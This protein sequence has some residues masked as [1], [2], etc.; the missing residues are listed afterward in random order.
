MRSATNYERHH[1]RFSCTW[2]MSWI[3]PL[4]YQFYRGLFQKSY[5]AS[6]RSFTSK[7]HS[8][9]SMHI[10][11]E[12][13]HTKCGPLYGYVSRWP[14]VNQRPPVHHQGWMICDQETIFCWVPVKQT[15]EPM[16]GFFLNPEPEV[17]NKIKGLSCHSNNFC[18]LCN[19]FQCQSM[20]G[21]LLSSTFPPPKA[22]HFWRFSSLIKPSVQS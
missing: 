6:V 15:L 19:P 4:D 7:V 10:T 8:P 12:T 1:T 20:D 9:Q 16:P 17:I 21:M 18:L 2:R 14:H 11:S 13:Y 5:S 22:W 3:G